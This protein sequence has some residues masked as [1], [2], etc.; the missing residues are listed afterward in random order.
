MSQQFTTEMN[1]AFANSS[2]VLFA[3]QSIQKNNIHKNT[4]EQLLEELIHYDQS[5]QSTLNTP[6]GAVSE[7]EYKFAEWFQNGFSEAYKHLEN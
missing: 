6:V 2:T 1:N 5:T 7:E 3:I 4:D